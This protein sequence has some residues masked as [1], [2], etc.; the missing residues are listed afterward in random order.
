MLCS[1]T[2]KERGLTTWHV[3]DE[4]EAKPVDKTKYNEGYELYQPLMP[5]RFMYST[6]M[7]Y[8]P[9]MPYKRG[10]VNKTNGTHC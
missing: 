8:I 2:L 5:K 9:F 10:A 1:G 4:D 6:I 3:S 7:K